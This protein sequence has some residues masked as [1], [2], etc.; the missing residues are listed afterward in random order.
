MPIAVWPKVRLDCTFLQAVALGLAIEGSIQHRP[1]AVHAS[2]PADQ[3]GGPRSSQGSS[4]AGP[5]P[6][7][8]GGPG[9]FPADCLRFWREP[10][11]IGP[12]LYGLARGRAPCFAG[13]NVPSPECLFHTT[14][15]LPLGPPQRPATGPSRPQPTPIL[16]SAPH[17]PRAPIF[18]W[19]LSSFQAGAKNPSN[20]FKPLHILNAGTSPLWVYEML[21]YMRADLVQS[22]LVESSPGHVFS[23]ASST[24]G[25][26]TF[27][28]LTTH[29]PGE[30]IRLVCI[31]VENSWKRSQSDIACPL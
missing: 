10:A 18:V 1:V 11:N 4:P 7:G 12:F 28:S 26:E 5:L 21:R 8:R 2:P 29:T 3:H 27:A 17:R 30:L 24:L 31:Q 13:A 16:Q 9:A 20:A 23:H 19:K 25:S 14:L 22:V 15:R 6:T